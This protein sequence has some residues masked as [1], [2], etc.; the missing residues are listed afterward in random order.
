MNGDSECRLYT[1]DLKPQEAE[2]CPSHASGSSLSS[3]RSSAARTTPGSWCFAGSTR[4]QCGC[5]PNLRQPDRARH[6]PAHSDYAVQ[7][8][9]CAGRA[10]VHASVEDGKASPVAF[11]YWKKSSPDDF[12]ET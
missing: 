6:P 9:S 2:S 8:R 10:A 12:F 3:F 5:R 1:V 11:V 7:A 4:A